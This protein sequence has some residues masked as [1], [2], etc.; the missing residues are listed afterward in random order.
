MPEKKHKLS[1]IIPVYN[2]ESTVGTLLEKV[3]SASPGI[4][5]EIII[6]NDGSTD[7]S[8]RKIREFLEKH[9][10]RGDLLSFRYLEK[11]NGGKGSALK[12]GI[13][14]STGSVVIIQDADLEYDP[15]DYVK[16]IR[17][18]LEGKSKVVYG[19]R[20]AENRNRFYSAPS[21]YLGGLILSFWIDL[22]YNGVLT[23]E[24][25]CYKTFDGDLIRSLKVEG[26]HFEWEVEVTCKLLRLGFSIEEVPISYSPRKPEGGKKIRAKDGFQG[27]WTALKWRFL[28][29]REEKKALAESPTAQELAVF[30]KVHAKAVRGVWIL[31]GLALLLRLAYALPGMETARRTPGLEDRIYQRYSDPVRKHFCNYSPQE[32]KLDIVTIRKAPLYRYFLALFRHAGTHRM[33]L[34][35]LAGLLLSV[36]GVYVVY[37]GA[38]A[39]CGWKA[40]LWA[41]SLYALSPLLIAAAFPGRLHWSFPLLLFFLTLQFCFLLRFFRT[42]L[43]PDLFCMAA[44][45]ALAALTDSVNAFWSLPAA[46]LILLYGKFTARRKL[47]YILLLLLVT[48]LLFFPALV[49]NRQFCGAW[50]IDGK[51]SERLF[52]NAMLLSLK[53]DR[54]NFDAN[55]RKT[56]KETW[57]KSLVDSPG[58]TPDAGT[59]FARRDAEMIRIILRHPLEY[60]KLLFN[61]NVLIP[62]QQELFR[63]Q[64]EYY[65]PLTE[66]ALLPAVTVLAYAVWL[67]T[68]LGVSWFVLLAPFRN[69]GFA[70]L[71]LLVTGGF[72]LLH[73]AASASLRDQIRVLPFFMMCA[74]CGLAFFFESARRIREEREAG[75]N[76]K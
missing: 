54:N 68:L 23:D 37:A 46:L 74:G 33:L 12:E 7:A 47:E 10:G 6:V 41:A 1:V 9:P 69:R 71:L 4:P 67:L 2:E 42:A 56:V 28:P 5:M 63:K 31:L 53:T 25:T 17:P 73:P 34:A 18:I 32:R 15:A 49:R 51:R 55:F 43:Q 21:F 72:H 39:V 50:R 13:A 11:P 66:K 52:L 44:S 14:A 35:E 24:L 58:K 30:G 70:L 40:G 26:D 48:F 76:G 19:S 61:K 59:Y 22:L 36:L 60:G 62:V 65:S 3:A 75:K 57:A 45:G 8:G 29:L 20:E 38:S 27:L 16:C 64:A